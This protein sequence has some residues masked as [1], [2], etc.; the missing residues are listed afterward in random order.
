[1]PIMS[2]R[3]H[4]TLTTTPTHVLEEITARIVAEMSP[5][6]VVLF[7]SQAWG[8]AE[9]ESDVDLL[10]VMETSDALAA[11]V[12]IG[13]ACRPPKLPMDVLVRTPAE[14]AERLRIGDAFMRRIVEHGRV[15]YERSDR[16]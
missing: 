5:E 14:V 15:L 12:R 11:E 1:M 8:E 2:A 16:S 9:E 13:R 10:V 6:R 3:G 7:G 4:Q